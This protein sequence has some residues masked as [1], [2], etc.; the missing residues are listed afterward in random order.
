MRFDQ[1]LADRRAIYE[2]MIASPEE[3]ALY[4]SYRRDAAAFLPI[5]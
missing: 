4:D 2:P 1:K 5:R 3:C